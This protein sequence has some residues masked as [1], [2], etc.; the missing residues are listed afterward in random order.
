MT[1]ATPQRWRLHSGNR[2]QRHAS[3]KTRYPLTSITGSYRRL[4]FRAH[5]GH[6]LVFEVNM[7]DKVLV[8]MIG[9]W[10]HARLTYSKQGWIVGLTLTQDYEMEPNIFFKIFSCMQIL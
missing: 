7:T 9:S 4:V 5:P 3:V 2:L 6:F 8:L 1:A 10:A